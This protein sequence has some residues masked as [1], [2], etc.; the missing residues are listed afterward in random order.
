VV[1]A[2]E[3]TIKEINSR[4]SGQMKFIENRKK[5]NF[6]DL[7]GEEVV[8]ENIEFMASK[9]YNCE[10]AV[11]T[12]VGDNQNHYRTCAS[13][14]VE[15]M[16]KVQESL[17][18]DG[19]GWSDVGVTFEK[20]M[21]NKQRYYIVNFRLL[22]PDQ[23]VQTQSPQNQP[24]PPKAPEEAIEKVIGVVVRVQELKKNGKTVKGIAIALESKPGEVLMCIDPNN[25][26]GWVEEKMEVIARVAPIPNTK[27]FRI[28]EILANDDSPF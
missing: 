28:E 13:V 10:N 20:R 12:I 4:I 7:L 27:Y 6:T 2:T 22:K 24:E 5:G 23:T 21:G 3:E 19:L 9:Y 8:I 11:F 25:F 14:I 17:G 1:Y 26:G 15:D 16:K 18:K